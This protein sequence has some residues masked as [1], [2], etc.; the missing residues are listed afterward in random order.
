MP[1]P[2]P[3]VAF[4]SEKW[5]VHTIRRTYILSMGESS[6]EFGSMAIVVVA[7]Y[8]GKN[9][10]PRTCFNDGVFCCFLVLGFVVADDVHSRLW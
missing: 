5:I 9:A 10:A 3:Y 8:T 1:E 7:E 6:D 2:Q 4:D